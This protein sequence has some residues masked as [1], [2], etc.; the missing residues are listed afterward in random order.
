M[1][2]SRGKSIQDNRINLQYENIISVYFKRKYF[3][4]LEPAHA[5][6]RGLCVAFVWKWP[7]FLWVTKLYIKEAQEVAK[8]NLTAICTT[9]WEFETN[10]WNAGGTAE[11]RD[12]A[13]ADVFRRRRGGRRD[14][15]GQRAT[16]EHGRQKERRAG[17]DAGGGRERGPRCV[18]LGFPFLRSSR[19]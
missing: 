2:F 18:W 1:N 16:S 6:A 7:F 5:R 19:P 8:N 14:I 10:R 4:T 9:M 17:T 12:P 15:F 3:S 11:R 13:P